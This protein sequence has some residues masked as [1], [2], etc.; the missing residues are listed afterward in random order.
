MWGAVHYAAYMGCVRINSNELHASSNS[1]V[2][3]LIRT[4]FVKLS[5]LTLVTTVLFFFVKKAYEA[6][7]NKKLG[8]AGFQ[9]IDC[10]SP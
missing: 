7:L 2:T 6:G 5:L 4:S 9:I 3:A 10:E 8:L 1:L